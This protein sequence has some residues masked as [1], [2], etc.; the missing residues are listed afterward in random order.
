M[1]RTD[2]EGHANASRRESAS[3]GH[4]SPPGY[5]SDLESDVATRLGILL[6]VRPI[7][8]DDAPPLVDFHQGL[9]LNSVYRRFLYVHRNLSAEEVERFTCVDYVNR[10]AL[11]AEDDSGLVA[12]ARYDRAPGTAEAE[13]AFVVA[14]Q[15]QHHGIGTLL[16]E[17]L[18]AAAWQR[19]IT[20]FVATALAENREMLQ[21]FA[22]SGFQVTTALAGGIMSV[23]F[24]IAPDDAYRTACQARHEHDHDQSVRSDGRGT[25]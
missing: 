7:R 4:A 2:L 25:L 17:R 18:A 13:V 15:Y 6:H 9:S 22:D 11:V 24:P 12:I 1:A 8:P 19:G 20:E 21:V 23:R 10:L 14:D 5:P 3:D 16:L